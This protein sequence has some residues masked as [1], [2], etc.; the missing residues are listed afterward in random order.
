VLGVATL[1]FGSTVNSLVLLVLNGSSFPLVETLVLSLAGI[2]LSAFA[3]GYLIYRLE[4]NSGSLK[5]RIRAF[6][7]G[8][9]KE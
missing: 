6:E 3:I 2:A 9:R 5:R 4:L 8:W 7:V 1:S